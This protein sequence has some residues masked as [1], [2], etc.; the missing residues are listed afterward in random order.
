MAF[1]QCSLGQW[2][3]WSQTPNESV[4]CHEFLEQR[5][6]LHVQSSHKQLLIFE[7]LNCKFPMLPLAKLANLLFVLG[8]RL[9]QLFLVGRRLVVPL[10]RDCLVSW[11]SAGQHFGPLIF[12]FH[13][14]FCCTKN[15]FDFGVLL[16]SNLKLNLLFN[17]P[18]SLL[19][20]LQ[21]C[22]LLLLTYFYVKWVNL[23][24]VTNNRDSTN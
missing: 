12:P 22:L 21:I 4:Q 11:E 23:S 3:E 7:H 13:S 19:F 10:Q 2:P 16:E 6:K 17:L 1:E 18:Q 8:F 5:R 14:H 24:T 9:P 20:W 15:A